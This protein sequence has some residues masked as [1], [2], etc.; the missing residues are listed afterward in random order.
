[1][2]AWVYGAL[3]LAA[4]GSILWRG[5]REER[6][7]VLTLLAVSTGTMLIV[8]RIGVRFD[9]PSLALLANE[10]VLLGISLTLAYRS[11]RFWP[12]PVAALEIAAFISLLMPL[13]GENLVPYA[14]GVA[15][16][17]WAYLQLLI[18]VLAVFREPN[19]SSFL[20]T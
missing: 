1:M 16:G 15:Q 10:T 7:F 4:V 9:E 17:L 11:N 3:L 12:M 19:K 20:R 5:G 13:F 6:V 14:M 8:A 18:V 2:F